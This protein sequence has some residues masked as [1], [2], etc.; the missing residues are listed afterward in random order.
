MWE[1]SASARTSYPTTGN[2]DNPAIRMAV[3]QAVKNLRRNFYGT[4][5]SLGRLEE[6]KH[7]KEQGRRI[8]WLMFALWHHSCRE[9]SMRRV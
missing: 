7:W 5:Q 2:Q 1:H 9:N 6:L 8:R 3:R 4:S